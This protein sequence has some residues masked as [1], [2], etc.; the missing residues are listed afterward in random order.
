MKLNMTGAMNCA[1]A[2]LSLVLCISIQAFAA[3]N[4]LVVT[5]EDVLGPGSLREAVILAN[6]A[7]EPTCIVFDASVST[8]VLTNG[9]LDLTGD[10]P[11]TIDGEGRVTITHEE[12]SLSTPIILR[13]GGHTIRGLTI[14][15]V[16]GNGVEVGGSNA[17]IDGCVIVGAE[18]QGI[19][20][21]GLDSTS[22]VTVTNCFVGV[23][24]DGTANANGGPNAI[25]ARNASQLSIGAPGAGNVIVAAEG[26]TGVQLVD[27]SDSSIEDNFIGTDPT[28]MVGLGGRIGISLQNSADVSMI[29]NLVASQTHTGIFTTVADGFVGGFVMQR[30]VLGRAVDGSPLP[31]A[32]GV[33]VSGYTGALIGGPNPAD[34]NVIAN[35]TG[36][37]IGIGFDT[38]QITM[39]HN[40][41]FDNGLD[42][43]IASGSNGGIAQPVIDSVGRVAG[44]AAPNS[45]VDVYTGDMGAENFVETV[46]ADGNGNFTATAFKGIAQVRV[47]ATDP[48]GNSSVLSAPAEAN[49]ETDGCA[50]APAAASGGGMRADSLMLVVLAVALYC[51]RYGGAP[52]SLHR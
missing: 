21:F 11:I 28:G 8:I 44:T 9:R 24:P 26:D 15:N 38:Q 41:I 29:N 45:L 43:D 10:Q 17:T 14:E 22:V 6:D 23:R 40:L 30:N 3:T 51:A 2:T 12:D 34:G 36:T 1:F 16:V 18:F 35:T 25:S 7:T 48:Q 4:T 31:N 50:S 19:S 27:C 32:A 20:I 33:V 52:I 5:T 13:D 49:L 46:Q 47:Q 37:A 39:R 42:I